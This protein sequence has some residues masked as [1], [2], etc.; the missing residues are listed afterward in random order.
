MAR[1]PQPGG[2]AG[3]WGDILNEYLA[4]AHKADGSLRNDSV[5]GA[6]ITDGS[7]QEAQLASSVQ[8]KLNASAGTP[9]WT[10]VTD[11]PAVIA[12]G[13]TQADARAAIGAGTSNV[14]IAG[15]LAGTPAAPV[16]A[17]GVI[18]SAKIADGTIVSG[19]ISVTAGIA[20][21]QLAADVQA[22][23][24]KADTALQSAPADGSASISGFPL[25][26]GSER[27]HSYPIELGRAHTAAASPSGAKRVLLAESWDT[28]G[29]LKHIWMASSDGDTSK[30]GFA[31]DGGTIRIYI[32]DSTMPV[33]EMTINDFF[34]Y[35]PLAGVYSNRRIARTKVGDGESSAYRYLHMPFQK[36][37]RVEVE[38]T[39]PNDV[40]F[41]GSADYTLLGD[42][43]SIGGQQ[44]NYQMFSAEEAGAAP[45][46]ALTVVDMAGAGQLES[47]WLSVEAAA[48]DTGVLEGNI[49]IYV[50]NATVPSWS[51]SGTEDAFNGGWYNVPVGGFPAG[52]AGDSANGGLS[53]TY[54]RFF[55]DDPIFFDTHIR[56]VMHA[57]QRNQGTINSGDVGVSG[58][59]GLWT[60]TPR[61]IN[62]RAPDTDVAAIFD[63]QFIGGAGALNPADWNQIG[64]KTQG[65]R[66]GSSVTF[67]YDGTAAGQDVRVARNNVALPV[68][69]WAETRV[70]ITDASHNGQ[71]AFLIVKG[72][73][74]DPYYGSAVHIQLSRFGQHNWVVMARD[75]FDE[76]FVRTIGSG[77]DM[78]NTWIKLACKVVGTTVVAFWQPEGSAVWQSIG[79]WTTGKAGTA[80]GIGTWTAGAEFDYLTVRPLRTVTS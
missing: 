12:A 33:V 36:Y 59:V 49:E 7:I 60:N 43:A 55:I 72:S 22:S 19:D 31:E 56:V 16:V 40:I 35:A 4:Q 69:Y 44:V 62:Y 66:T 52:R 79:S 28:P 54:Y 80:V 70:R 11:K 23:L 75:D 1:L 25:R 10:D 14:V 63:D 61:S 3:N 30:S 73:V 6:T 24:D 45:Y 15:D 64:G 65:Q 74:P 67:A 58:F 57:G 37:C 47:L 17:N 18:T 71:D 20:K 34:A 53:A 50:D 77:R 13:A 26:I 2:D 21:T 42:F 48:D 39:S 46:D 27:Q 5:T 32:D 38:N 9:S 78:T 8:A 68:N 29:I 51:S 41:F 76:V